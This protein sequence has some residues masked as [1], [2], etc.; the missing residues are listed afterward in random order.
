MKRLIFAALAGA[1]IYSVASV[2]SAEP[3]NACSIY[4][5]EG[6]ITLELV[7]VRLVEPAI[8]DDEPEVPVWADGA[9]FSVWGSFWDDDGTYLYFS[10]LDTEPTEGVTP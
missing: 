9:T 8:A 10:P 3:A 6:E 5:P 4:C 2:P 1:A 7:E